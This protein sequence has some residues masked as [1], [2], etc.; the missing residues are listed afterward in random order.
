MDINLIE[1]N[2]FMNGD[3]LIAII[4]DAASTGISL[5]ADRAVKNQRKR[6]HIT[7]VR[8]T[9]TGAGD[10]AA[11]RQLVGA[12]ARDERANPLAPLLLLRLWL[13]LRLLLRIALNCL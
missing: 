1:K 13:W 8:Q 3:K 2:S 10:G 4:S 9:R 7:M 12:C 6:M 5:H 11:A